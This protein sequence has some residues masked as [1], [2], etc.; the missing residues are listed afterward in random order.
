MQFTVRVT[1]V[2][3]VSNLVPPNAVLPE[4]MV[5]CE[6]CGSTVDIPQDRTATNPYGWIWANIG[7]AIIRHHRECTRRVA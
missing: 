4:F 5:V 2:P 6:G 7:P 1:D 3:V